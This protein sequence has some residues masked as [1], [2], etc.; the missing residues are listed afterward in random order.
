M[1]IRECDM[2]FGDT[3]PNKFHINYDK[4]VQLVEALKKKFMYRKK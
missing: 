3:W 4:R 2:N 1:R